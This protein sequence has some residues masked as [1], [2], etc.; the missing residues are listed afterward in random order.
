M[1]TVSYVSPLATGLLGKSEGDTAH[2]AGAE[3]E[4][5]AVD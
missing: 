5:V 4:I 2:I 1:G 3:F